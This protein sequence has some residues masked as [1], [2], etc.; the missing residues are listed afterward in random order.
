MKTY[1]VYI[2]ECSDNSFYTG[3]TSDLNRRLAEHHEGL[4]P[5]CFTAKRR[6][7][8]LV[9]T[10]EFTDVNQAISFEKQIKGWGRK[11]KLALIERRWELLK[12]L[13]QCKNESSHLNYKGGFDSAQP[14]IDSAQPKKDS[15]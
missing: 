9:F 3:V 5:Q 10:Q 7:L 4:N 6:P 14:D 13:S 15:V 11:K 2:L 1:I 8:N 12:E